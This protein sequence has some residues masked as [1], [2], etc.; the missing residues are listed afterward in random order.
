[1][2][3]DEFR[4]LVD[5]LIVNYGPDIEVKIEGYYSEGD[6]N[7]DDYTRGNPVEDILIDDRSALLYPFSHC[8]AM[9]QGYS[10]QSVL[11]EK[12]VTEEERWKL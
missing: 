12:T 8:V 3:A 11:L 9:R 2:R 10:Y 1:M 7:G 5:K 6:G 4:S